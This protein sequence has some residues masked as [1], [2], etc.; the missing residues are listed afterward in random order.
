MATLELAKRLLSSLLQR[1]IWQWG[2]QTTCNIKVIFF[3]QAQPQTK[4]PYVPDTSTTLHAS[5][6]GVYGV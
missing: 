3:V 4:T 2:K 5:F 6:Q 1:V